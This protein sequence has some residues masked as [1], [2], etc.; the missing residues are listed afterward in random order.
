MVRVY[1][2]QGCKNDKP[3][4]IEVPGS[5][6]NDSHDFIEMER[7][8]IVQVHLRGHDPVVLFPSTSPK[9]GGV[10]DEDSLG[11]LVAN[12]G[13]NIRTHDLR[14]Y[15]LFKYACNLYAI[16]RML[17]AEGD[18]KKVNVQ[19]IEKKLTGQAGHESIST[20][21][22]HYVDLAKVV[23]GDRKEFETL[24]DEETVLEQR[25]A[26]IRSTRE[27]YEVARATMES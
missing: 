23:T 2:D 16:E 19:Y 27:Q 4:Y 18:K 9:N 13:L 12:T 6:I 24:E 1:L 21:L 20:T 7:N 14:A 8:D 17:A 3:R 11:Q 5:L 25:L 10:M 22:R 15:G 26:M